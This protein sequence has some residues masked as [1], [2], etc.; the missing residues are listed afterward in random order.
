M[1]PPCTAGDAMSTLQLALKRQWF[2]DI[3]NGIKTEEYREVNPY[4]S[5]RLVGRVFDSLVLTL[6]YPCKDDQTRRIVLPWR[7]YTIK[8]I[9]HPQWQNREVSVFAIRLTG[10]L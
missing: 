2:E 1:E 5:M 8:T 6:G 3:K 7:G 9:Q 10:D 4:W